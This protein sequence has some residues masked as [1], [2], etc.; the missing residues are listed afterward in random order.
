M[1]DWQTIDTAPRDGTVID[2]WVSNQRLANCFWLVF[3]DDDDAH[4]C[5]QYAEMPRAN[6]QIDE[7]PT[8]WRPLP[9]PPA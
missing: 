1:N 6:F 4:W 5:Q 3:L 8:H 2:L 7:I 9:E